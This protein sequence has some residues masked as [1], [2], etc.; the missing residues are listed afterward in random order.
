M[1]LKFL[2]A[3]ELF[4]LMYVIGVGVR[5]GWDAAPRIKANWADLLRDLFH[6]RR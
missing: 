5:F 1:F 2:Q 6:R 4:L 3:V